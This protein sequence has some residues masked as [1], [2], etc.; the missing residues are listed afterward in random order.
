MM[1][2]NRALGGCILAVLISI[3]LPCVVLADSDV[4]QNTETGYVV[5][6]EDY[7]NLLSAEEEAELA[8]D[9]KPITKYGNAAFVSLEDNNSSTVSYAENHASEFIGSNG[10]MFLIDMD[11]REI[12]IY[13]KGEVWGVVTN[14]KARSITDNVYQYAS[15]RHYYSCASE[16][17]RQITEVLEGGG[18]PEP[19]KII[20]GI[21]LSLWIGVI[22]NF[23]YVQKTRKQEEDENLPKQIVHGAGTGAGTIKITS[24]DVYK[25]VLGGGGSGGGGG[26]GSFGG[27]GGSSGGGGGHSF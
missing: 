25:R 19:M 22:I 4:Y 16:A 10:S 23:H 7:A 24:T 9:M 15:T 11:N 1:R 6:I 3:M 17:F 20:S 5:R 18:I 13:S 21:L 12:Y 8:E 14:S 26:G 27:G 2:R